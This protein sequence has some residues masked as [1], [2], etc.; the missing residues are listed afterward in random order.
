MSSITLF[1]GGARSGKSAHAEQYARR[2]GE[3]IIYVATAEARDAEMQERIAHHQQRRPATWPTI[4]APLNVAQALEAVPMGAV[5]LL[6]CLSLL[7]TNLLLAHEAD[8]EPAIV[9]EVNAILAVAQTRALHLI[10]VTNEVGMGIVPA[11]PLGRIYR[12]VLGRANQ[13]VAAAADAVYLVVSGIP[14]EIK[15]LAAAW[16]KEA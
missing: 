4:E 7:V 10:I 9:A 1:T 15:A 11:Y 6:D 14:I 12:D 5:V 2:L 3:P 13:Q 8:P 16:A